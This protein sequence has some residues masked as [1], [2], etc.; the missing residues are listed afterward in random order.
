MISNE[1]AAQVMSHLLVKRQK[2]PRRCI[3]SV[4]ST[5]IN[6][7]WLFV[8]YFCFIN[9]IAGNF[10]NGPNDKHQ[11]YTLKHGIQR[12]IRTAF[13]SADKTIEKILY[14]F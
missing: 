1:T 14:V 6:R 3:I 2:K 13:T 5:H 8:F 12:D 7:W 10:R 11:I 4:R 9:I